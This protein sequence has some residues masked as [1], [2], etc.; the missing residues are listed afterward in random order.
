MSTVSRGEGHGARHREA[1]LGARRDGVA[2][3][4]Q[5]RRVLQHLVDAAL[6]LPAHTQTH[7][8]YTDYALCICRQVYTDSLM[9]S[10]FTVKLKCN[11]MF[12]K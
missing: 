1:G 11:V 6:R 5:R 8:V 3:L 2:G 10:S 7:I 9:V 4:A 12:L